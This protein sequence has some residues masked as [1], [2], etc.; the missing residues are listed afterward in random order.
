MAAAQQAFTG[1]TSA[2]IFDAILKKAPTAPVRL[3]LDLPFMNR[4]SRLMVGSRSY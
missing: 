2:V 1:S 4:S 3:N